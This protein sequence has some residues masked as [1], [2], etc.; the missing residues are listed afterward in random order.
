MNG[1]QTALNLLIG[2]VATP[3]LVKWL[4]LERVGAQKAYS[5]WFGYLT[6]TDLGLGGAFSVL[7][8]RARATGNR[9][10]IAYVTQ[11]GIRTLAMLAM[12]AIPTGLVLAWFMPWLVKVD[13]KFWW[14]LRIA[15]FISIAMLALAPFAMYRTVLDTAQ[16]GYV[17]S[18][19]LL[20]QSLTITGLSLLFAYRGYGLI[21][22]SVALVIGLILFTLL[23]FRWGQ[24][25]LKGPVIPLKRN[26][27]PRVDPINW[28]GLW[29]LA[30]PIGVTSAGNRLN[31]MTDTIVIGHLLGST[32]VATLFLTQR[33]IFLAAAQVNTV[34]NAS[35]AGLA[36][37]KN[38]GQ[39]VR[40]RER[41]I[42]LCR[43]LVGVGIVLVGTIA[44]YNGHF[45][46]L[47]VGAKVYA[48]DTLTLLTLAQGLIFG[49]LLLFAWLIDTVGDTRHRLFVSTTGSI[50]NLVLSIIFVKM[51]GI[52]GVT[53]GTVC[54][55]LLTD[56]WFLPYLS[57]KRYGL[58]PAEIF[59]AVARGLALGLPWAAAMWLLSHSH[60][61][62]HGWFGL[63]GE[64][65]VLG[66][67]SLWYCW[68]M[69]LAPAD[70]EA[71]RGR[72]GRARR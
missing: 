4:T 65:A 44:A 20:A 41:M 27:L 46:R 45:V 63:I 51:I 40:L 2:I 16:R 49:F 5:D 17:V 58:A 10:A 7:I 42:E 72:L 15:S 11:R 6:L 70:R 36:E 61:P 14:E 35:W 60:T 52:A 56:A 69:I 13:P 30:W 19:A 28:N 53:L 23:T 43:L 64:C 29:R 21:G 71:W 50:L 3:L 34:T 25:E 48:G 57:C 47:W 38:T 12:V 59:G 66:S 8:L 22:Q 26:P 39:L 24:T 18:I 32:P 62:P 31:L 37:L 9:E 1:I 55:Y 67:A 68:V 54:A 33:L